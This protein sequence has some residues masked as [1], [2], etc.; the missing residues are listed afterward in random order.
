AGVF[1]VSHMTIVDVQGKEAHALLAYLLAN[2]VGK[3][4]APGKALYSCMLREDGGVIDDLT[5]YL[6][7]EGRYRLIANAATYDKDMDWISRQAAGREVEVI[8]RNELALL[9]LQGPNAPQEAAAVLPAPQRFLALDPFTA[10]AFD[11]LFV[12]RTGYTGEDGFEIMM[13]AKRAPDLWDALIGRGVVAC[14]LAARDTLR[15]ES[16]MNLYGADMDETVSPLECGLGWTVSLSGDRRF[17]GREAIERQRK[18]RVQRVRVG[19]VIEDRGVLR[20]GYPVHSD[21]GE[22]VITS[23]SFGP[24]VGRSVALARVPAGA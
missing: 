9:A 18:A 4:D 13:P 19:L 10:A 5:V 8:E 20:A 6:L 1:D 21:R 17:I 24:T 22:G 16:G 7:G 3:L 23:G 12:A 2:D 11:E 14:G 15:R